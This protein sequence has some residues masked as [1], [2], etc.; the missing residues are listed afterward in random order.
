MPERQFTDAE[1]HAAIEALGDRERFRE[2]EAHVTR[3]APQLTRILNEALAEGGH[4]NVDVWT[5]APIF[6][7]SDAMNLTNGNKLPLVIVMDCL[8]G[9]F[10]APAIDCIG[11]A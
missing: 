9:Y 4:G 3:I 10:I 8:N 7:A 6:S 5:G 2:A 11:V 1:L